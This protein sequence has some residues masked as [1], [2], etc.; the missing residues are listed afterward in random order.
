MKQS[1]VL[2]CL[3]VLLLLLL[4]PASHAAPECDALE[5][6]ARSFTPVGFDLVHLATVPI[7]MVE[8]PTRAAWLD[9]IYRSSTFLDRTPAG[10]YA[11]ADVIRNRPGVDMLPY[12]AWLD[13]Q[14]LDGDNVCELT[15]TLRG[16][17]AGDTTFT[18]LGVSRGGAA[19]FEPLLYFHVQEVRTHGPGKE[20]DQD[21]GSIVNG[22]GIEAATWTVDVAVQCNNCR[23]VDPAPYTTVTKSSIFLWDVKY[24]VIEST[25]FQA[26]PCCPDDKVQC[27]KSVVKIAVT[28]GG[29]TSVTIKH[30][31][32]IE[33]KFEGWFGCTWEIPYTF[34][35]CC[36]K[37]T[38]TKTTSQA[39][40][41]KRTFAV[42]EPVCVSGDNLPPNSVVRIVVFPNSPGLIPGMPLPPAQPGTAG[43]LFTDGSGEVAGTDLG[44]VPPRLMPGYVPA[45][46]PE[47]DIGWDY[48]VDTNENGMWD[49][50]EP[51]LDVGEHAGFSSHAAASVPSAALTLELRGSPNPFN[52]ATDIAYDI[53]QPGRLVLDIHDLGGRLVRV[54]F[55]G[56]AA[57]ARGVVR[58]DGADDAG[59]RVGSG[60]YV[61]RLRAHGQE[62]TA[63]L[64]VIK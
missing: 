26:A 34:H 18:T 55:V 5:V 19:V 42:G 29:K 28:S 20:S 43:W 17:A 3:P 35:V 9:S 4:P 44:G 54:L 33:V 62:K 24:E 57:P 38:T 46:G 48:I 50:M 10:T 30:D 21:G 36:A 8:A 45:S 27:V 25:Y 59:R 49:P 53:G 64:A 7:G 51:A 2:A 56:E 12:R 31:D 32:W 58:W 22:F 39:G 15:W 61:A 63:K 47:W 40:V 14:V 6:L 37:A 16:T 23:I 13:T 1:I 52:P 60:V 41:P 11:V